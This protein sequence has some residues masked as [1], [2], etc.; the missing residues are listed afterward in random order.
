MLEVAVC[1]LTWTDEEVVS[2]M[3]VWSNATVQAELQ[4]AY[5]NNHIY[6]RIV[7]ELAALQVPS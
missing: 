2:F 4:G 3:D 5:R 6:H 7:N 1:R